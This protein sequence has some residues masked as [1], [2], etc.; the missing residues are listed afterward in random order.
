MLALTGLQSLY[1]IYPESHVSKDWRKPFKFILLAFRIRAVIRGKRN[2]CIKYVRPRY[3][4]S[5]KK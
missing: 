3:E 2:Y 1:C 4:E 5:G